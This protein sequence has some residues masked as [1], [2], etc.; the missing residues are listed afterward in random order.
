M[1]RFRNFSLVVTLALL[2]AGCVSLPENHDR[3]VS[4]AIAV[5]ND[6]SIASSL[7]NSPESNLSEDSG[8]FLLPDGPDAFIARVIMARRAEHSIDLNTFIYHND[9]IG[10][11]LMQELLEAAD[12]GVRVR[13]LFDDIWLSE[14]DTKL[15]AIDAHPNLEIRLFNPLDRRVPK[16]TQF[17]TRWGSIMRRMHN[18]SIVVD[19]QVAILGGRNI[20]SEYFGAHADVNFGDLDVLLVG[21]V[22]P[23][24]STAFDAYWNSDLAYPLSTLSQPTDTPAEHQAIRHQL[25]Q[26]VTNFRTTNYAQALQESALAI[27]LSDESIPFQWG[28]AR[29]VADSPEKITSSRKRTDLHLR[30][31]IETQFTKAEQELIIVTPY[32]IPGKQGLNDLA[33]LA[34]SGVRVRILTNSMGTN[35]HRMVHAHYSKYRRDLLRAGIEIFELKRERRS[36]LTAKS[37]ALSKAQVLHA[38]TFI[39]DR[40]Q[41]FVGSLNFDPRSWIENTEIGVVLQ[42]PALGSEIGLWFDQEAEKVAYHLSLQSTGPNSEKVIWTDPNGINYPVEPDSNWWERVQLRLFRLLPIESLL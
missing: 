14:S 13:L 10:Q 4:Y 19:N 21:Q 38:K 32:L 9:E 8:F 29:V 40:N 41:V 25:Q 11:T 36:E 6:S 22:V 24:V 39:V 26:E 3:S 37:T 15:A 34:A 42:S 23:S 35:N 30:S 28:E 17:I 12:R 33:G 20:G 1:L 18:K 7:V 27:H 2:S 5:G 16:I 31:S